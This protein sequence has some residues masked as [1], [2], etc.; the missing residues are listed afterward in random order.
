MERVGGLQAQEPA[1]PSIALWSRLV[2]FEASALDRALQ[3]RRA[4]K[5]T[6]MRGTLHLVSAAD[7]LY[8]QPALAPTLQGFR[9]QDRFRNADVADIEAVAESA[10][11][12]AGVPR[13]NAEIHAH[14][15]SLALANGL[16]G[17]DVWWRVRRHA[18]FVH[19]PADAPWSF[20]RRPTYVAGR[21]W[22]RGRAFADPASSMERLIRR[23]LGAFGPAAPSDIAT[24]SGLPVYRIRAAVAATPDLLEFRDHAGRTL[25]DLPD[26]PRPS[27]DVPA[28]PRF[29]AM[30]D[31]VLLAY[32]DRTRI[33]SDAHRPLVIARNGDVLPTFLVD[34][35]V[36]GLWWVE[37]DGGRTR[38]A[39][40]PF[41]RL[42][43]VARRA[44]EAEAARLAAFYEPLEPALYVRYRSSR[45][46]R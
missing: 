27:P 10:L 17:E 38:I 6:L 9:F 14:L 32:R 3:R 7:Y 16:K 28:P 2:D 41:G 25:L 39:L 5:A 35:A 40:E 30:W 43:R 15:G 46:R 4:V 26:A 21:S 18:P 22:L 44:L 11:T 36:A 8:L 24:W 13:T 1:S 23:Y 31:S 12:F 20:G 33:L 34:G 37:P 42:A 29:L 19:V 45:A